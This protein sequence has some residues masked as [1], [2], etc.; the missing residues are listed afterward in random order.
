[1][2]WFVARDVFM[3]FVSLVGLLFVRDHAQL[4]APEMD[5]LGGGGGV[6]D[7]CG[8]LLQNSRSQ[9]WKSRTFY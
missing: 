5:L 8:S 3:L 1:M 6:A 9:N 7:D 2:V 4:V